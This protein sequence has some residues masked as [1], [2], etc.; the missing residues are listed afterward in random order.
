MS[1]DTNNSR[2]HITI[3]LIC[4]I[5]LLISGCVWF[6]MAP[7][8][9]IVNRQERQ[10]SGKSGKSGKSKKRVTWAMDLVDIKIIPNRQSP[11]YVKL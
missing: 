9:C 8:S 10:T 5:L 1:S 4:I 3:G 11:E 7:K 2:T 6:N